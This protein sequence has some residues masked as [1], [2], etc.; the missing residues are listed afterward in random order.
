MNDKPTCPLRKPCEF[1]GKPFGRR[2]RQNNRNQKWYLVPVKNWEATPCCSRPC[3]SR[4][5]AAD[6]RKRAAQK[7]AIES[8]TSAMDAFLYAG[9]IKQ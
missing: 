7:K 4:K 8:D 5:R 9:G 2:L 6:A 3:S 1:C